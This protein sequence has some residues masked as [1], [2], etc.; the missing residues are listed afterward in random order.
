MVLISWL[1]Y[2]I[3]AYYEG[4][5]WFSSTSHFAFLSLK[6]K[7]I[8][9]KRD[10]LSRTKQKTPNTS[11]PRIL[12][13]IILVSFFLQLYNSWDPQSTDDNTFSLL[14]THLIFSTPYLYIIITTTYIPPFP[15]HLSW[16]IILTWALIL[17]YCSVHLLSHSPRKLSHY[18]FGYW[19]SH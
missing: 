5:L 3:T 12:F 1:D 11:I 17:L 6:R 14:L 16:V 8:F 15:S 10:F 7:C 9:Y 13:P 4:N 18:I 2:V 19:L